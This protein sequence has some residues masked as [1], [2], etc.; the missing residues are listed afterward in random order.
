MSPRERR[1]LPRVRRCH[2]TAFSLYDSNGYL[3]TQSLARTLDISMGGALL[4]T[5]EPMAPGDRIVLDMQVGD[6]ILPLQGTVV[7]VDSLPN[8]HYRVG[9]CFQQVAAEVIAEIKRD[10]DALPSPAGDNGV[11]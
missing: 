6:R 10:L 3:K 11:C 9:V 2:L 8:N 7:H 1:R 5:V 4:E